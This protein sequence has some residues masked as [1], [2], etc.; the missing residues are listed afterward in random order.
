MSGA[1]AGA[2]TSIVGTS[3]FRARLLRALWRR[4]SV[5]DRLATVVAVLYL[6][7][8]IAYAFGWKAPPGAISYTLAI[9]APLFYASLIFLLVRSRNWIRFRLLWSLRNRLILAYV[10]IAVIPIALLLAMGGI[11]FYMVDVEVAAHLLTDD[12][13]TRMH[14]VAAISRQALAL[15]EASAQTK[16]LGPADLDREPAVRALE[17]SAG[18]HL[19]GLSIQFAAAAD[20]QAAAANGAATEPAFGSSRLV[21]SGSHLFIESSAQAL[22]SPGHSIAAS[23]RLPVSPELLDGMA[24]ELGPINFLWRLSGASSAARPPPADTANVLGKLPAA[25]VSTRTRKLPPREGWFDFRVSGVTTFPAFAVEKPGAA[26]APS[27][28]LAAFSVRPSSLKHR[29]QSS[30]GE[31]STPYI[32]VLFIIAGLFLVLGLL[33]LIAGFFLTRTITNTVNQLDEATH[34]VK[35]R[36]FSH[37]ISVVR[38]DQ[39]AA[40]AESFNSMTASIED[41][42][43]QQRQRQ[44]L[45]NELAIAREVQTELFPRSLPVVSG[46]RLGAVC[47]AARVVSGDYY[48]CIQLDS[49]RVAMAVAD[50]SGKGI[51]AALLMASLNAALRSLV[52][53]DG[54]GHTNTGDLVQRLNRHLLLN[55]SDDRYATLFFSIY[56]APSRTLHYTNAGHLPPLFVSGDRIDRLEHGGPV[57]GLLDGCTYEQASIP[58]EPGSLLVV[59]SDGITEPENAYGEEFGIDRLVSEVVRHRQAPPERLCNELIDAVKTWCAPAEPFDDQTVLVARME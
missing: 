52:V 19:P 18:A 1:T 10:L 4:A 34:Y 8:E 14:Q 31:F 26:P 38:H 9:L 3:M 33:G 41:L 50:I 45:E 17:H 58:V 12:M 37:R 53:A 15:V 54:F 28:V 57:I 13:N 21:A 2:G 22:V 35:A 43:E 48:D 23:V 29:L 32:I 47:R 55:T 11:L 27:Q 49:N 30:L 7:A 40:L 39:L 46:L 44:R 42:L 51:S 56:D 25:S 6:I 5:W 59:Y 20:G 36:D 16:S 24:R